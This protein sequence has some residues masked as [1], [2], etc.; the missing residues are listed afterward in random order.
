MCVVIPFSRD[1]IPFLQIAGRDA[2]IGALA[3]E[4]PESRPVEGGRGSLG[5]A[6]LRVAIYS[7]AT[8]DLDWEVVGAGEVARL[9]GLAA[10]ADSTSAQAHGGS[11]PQR[12]RPP[13][14]VTRRG[15]ISCGRCCREPIGSLDD[16]LK[17]AR[18]QLRRSFIAKKP[19]EVALFLRRVERLEASRAAMI[20]KGQDKVDPY[21]AARQ[22]WQTVREIDERT[23]IPPPPDF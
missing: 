21:E 12:D 9:V 18:V 23:I 20:E 6:R 13:G 17:I 3:E 4:S 5:D 19:Q 16:E 22:I 10:R 11:G 15:D 8:T 14:D 7:S 1:C 2:L